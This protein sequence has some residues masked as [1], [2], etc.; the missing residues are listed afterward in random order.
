MSAAVGPAYGM[1]RLIEVSDY[2]R[3][4]VD[5][6][7]APAQGII[8]DATTAIRSTRL[9]SLNSLLRPSLR[10]MPLTPQCW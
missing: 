2:V 6:L 10:W 9:A 4:V 7:R 3:D 5:A 8:V 1:S